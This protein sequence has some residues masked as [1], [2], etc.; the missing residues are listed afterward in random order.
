MRL[1]HCATES[2]SERVKLE[3]LQPLER[4]LIRPAERIPVDGRVV[5]GESYLGE[6]SISGEPLPV[7]KKKGDMLFAGSLNQEGSLIKLAEKTGK[8]SLLG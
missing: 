2:T 4:L 7:V 8:D 3:E 6:S 5:K 1:L